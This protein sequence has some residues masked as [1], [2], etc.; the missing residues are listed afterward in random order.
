M[1][2]VT[3]DE[4]AALG[5]YVRRLADLMELRDWTMYVDTGDVQD[6]TYAATVER[7]YGRKHARIRVCA[8]WS[9]RTPEQQRQ[10]ICHELLH[11][12]LGG[13]D[14]AVA[15]LDN[16]IKPRLY[17]TWRPLFEH[18]MEYAVDAIA[19]ALAPRLPLPNGDGADVGE[20]AA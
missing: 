15:V 14:D 3:A 5:A 9:N 6:S 1:I 8:E 16:A 19:D 17:A 4:H 2:A 18:Q 13:V 12:L 7:V 10:N 11:V 20:A